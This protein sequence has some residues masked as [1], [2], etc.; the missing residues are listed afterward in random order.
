MEEREQQ[1]TPEQ[2]REKK[3]VEDWIKRIDRQRES[4]ADKRQYRRMRSWRRMCAG[5]QP[6][7]KSLGDDFTEDEKSDMRLRTNMYY[8]TFE[9]ILPMIYAKM[10]EVAA[11]AAPFVDQSAYEWVRAFAETAQ[12]LL[13]KTTR[14][15]R[16][17]ALSEQACRQAMTTSIAYMKVVY[18]RDYQRDPAIL[19]RINDT[20]DNIARLQQLIVATGG[21]QATNDPQNAEHLVMLESL[22]ANLAALES[23]PEVQIAHGVVY[24]RVASDDLVI[25]GR[26][27]ELVNYLQAGWIAQQIWI[28][29]EDA[30]GKY[31]LSREELRK[32]QMFKRHDDDDGTHYAKQE[33]VAALNE[34]GEL[35]DG[36]I[37]VLEIWCHDDMTVYTTIDGLSRWALAPYQPQRQPQQWYPYA[38]L[39]F[40]PVDGRRWPLSDIELMQKLVSEYNESRDLEALHKKR[41]V[42]A[43]VGYKG[44][45]SETDAR[46]LSNPDFHEMVLISEPDQPNVP[47][48]SLLAA[49]PYPPFDP[50]IYDVS[51]IR[52][53]MDM[54][55]G[56][57]EYQRSSMIKPKTATEAEF[58]QQGMASRSL[59]RQDT[60]EEFHTQLARMTLEIQLQEMHAQDVLSI[61]GEG[62]QWPDTVTKDEVYNLVSIEVRAGSSG[63]P[64]RQKELETWTKMMPIVN[65]AILQIAQ[66]LMQGTPQLAKAQVELLKE[67]FRRIDERVDVEKFLPGAKGTDDG[68]GQQDPMQNPAVQEMA[69]K[70]QEQ[71]QALQQENQ[72]LKV[73]LKDKGEA[74]AA[75]A[76]QDADTHAREQQRIANDHAATLDAQEREHMLKMHQLEQ[77][78][79]LE[80]R[81]QLEK[82]KV[83]HTKALLAALQTA[84]DKE[85]QQAEKEKGADGESKSADDRVLKMLEEIKAELADEDQEQERRTRAVVGY[86]KGPRTP[87]RLKKVLAELTASDSDEE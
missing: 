38:A 43:V 31:Q 14:T 22:R 23:E 81:V 40:N 83:E 33:G 52:A 30:Q 13:N 44:N 64:N 86:L 77:E 61:V 48:D 17:K 55:S 45:F 85:A 42:P 70:A 49:V 76:Q 84:T 58:M 75:K 32:C 63:R 60:V 36:Y 80:E 37:R 27:R 51:N 11:T 26:V 34:K 82:L 65:Q 24:D 1:L 35:C 12:I 19:N 25:D 54:V 79:A 69:Q 7:F 21:D 71:I 5:F 73:Q 28:S 18:Q 87:E 59:K 67:M 74:A 57:P 6:Q 41:A 4:D 8:S 15:T 56:V 50:R 72:Q 47:I 66:A 78:L 29:P 62:A 39:I 3:V 10:P 53:D 2:E 9:S 20:Q 16:L 46:K 68:M